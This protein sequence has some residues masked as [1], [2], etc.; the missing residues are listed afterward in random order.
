MGNKVE[1]LNIEDERILKILMTE[2]ITYITIKQKKNKIN[3]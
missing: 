2:H 1:V 3:I